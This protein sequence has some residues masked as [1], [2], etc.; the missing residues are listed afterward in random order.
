[1]VRRCACIL[2]VEFQ[3]QFE[4]VWDSACTKALSTRG[5]LNKKPGEIERNV[6]DMISCGGYYLNLERSLGPG[7]SLVLGLQVAETL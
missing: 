3:Q 6:K 2:L 4:C 5:G 7:A 1:M